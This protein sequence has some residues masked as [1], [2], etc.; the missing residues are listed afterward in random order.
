QPE[1]VTMEDCLGRTASLEELHHEVESLFLRE[2]GC[3]PDSVVYAPG[4]V[5]IIGEH[6]DYNDGFVLPMALPLVTMMAGKRIESNVVNVVTGGKDV[7]TRLTPGS[8]KDICVS[9]PVP[10]PKQERRDGAQ[11][12]PDVE[13]ANY[14]KGVLVNYKRLCGAFNSAIVST[15]PLGGGLSSSAALEVATYTL[16]EQLFPIDHP[17]TPV[18]KAL[19]CQ[20]AE[21]V[22]ANVPCGIMDQFVSVMA[23]ENHLLCIDC[24]SMRV[25]QVP[26]QNPHVVVLITNSNVRHNLGSSEYP[27]R[28]QQCEAASKAMGKRSLR[29]CTL[30][31]LEAAGIEDETI[32]RR[33]HH[34]ISENARV[35]QAIESLKTTDYYRLGALMNESHASLREDF[36][37]SCPEIDLLVDIAQRQP[38]VYGSRIT[39]GGFGGCTVTLV[40]R[41]HVDDLMKAIYDGYASPERRP[42]FYVCNASGGAAVFNTGT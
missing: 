19:A 12:I 10:D 23:T 20:E 27:V 17:V 34:V 5:N 40:K 14:V 39:G 8:P 35:Q 18:E 37:V 4:R 1:Q 22:Y 26:F 32:K 31:D 33:A 16:L 25:T 42:N 29:L 41:S 7:T 21:H 2:F 15:V 11:R 36:A 9:F 38:G 24:E 6:T 28:R 13:W 3:K 30:E